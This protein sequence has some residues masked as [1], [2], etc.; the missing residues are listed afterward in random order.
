MATDLK[1]EAKA[2]RDA[3]VTSL[4]SG[5]VSDFQDLLAQQVNL[6]RH[7]IRS[8]FEKTKDAATLQGIGVGVALLGGLLLSLTLV[9]LLHWWFP[10]LPLWGAHGIVGL[11]ALVVGGI[12]FFAGKAR[13]ASFNPLPDESLDALKENVRWITNPTT[14]K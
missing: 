5:I 4:V 11:T 3:S 13:F 10:E 9:H 2:E 6:L 8:D 14:P 1:V 12:L 7:E